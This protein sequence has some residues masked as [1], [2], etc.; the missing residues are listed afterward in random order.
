VGTIR[1]ES[2][3]RSFRDATTVRLPSTWFERLPDDVSVFESLYRWIVKEHGVAAGD[4]LHNRTFAGQ[5]ICRKL[6][7]AERRR[8]ARVHRVSGKE[9]EE[10]LNWSSGNAGPLEQFAGCAIAG[11]ALIVISPADRDR[12]HDVEGE[13]EEEAR[14][15]KNPGNQA[16]SCGR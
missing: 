16:T 3:V 9:L 2:I 13:F 6:H 1:P 15:R 11:D 14:Q 12:V 10:R 8:L 7:A 4:A 5:Q